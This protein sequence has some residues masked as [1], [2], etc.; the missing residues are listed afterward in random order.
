[1]VLPDKQRDLVVQVIDEYVFAVYQALRMRKRNQHASF[2]IQQALDVRQHI[3]S[4]GELMAIDKVVLLKILLRRLSEDTLLDVDDELEKEYRE[5]LSDLRAFAKQL[6]TD[7][8]VRMVR[9]NVMRIAEEILISDA[10]R[11]RMG[12]YELVPTEKIETYAREERGELSV[13]ARHLLKTN[14]GRVYSH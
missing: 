13:I 11:V 2:K 6:I 4:D 5:I 14:R 12:L 3:Y 1:M 9:P 7:T 8:E 10:E